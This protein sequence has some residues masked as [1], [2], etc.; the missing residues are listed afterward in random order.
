MRNRPAVMLG[1]MSAGWFFFQVTPT[2][3][4][5]VFVFVMD[6][7]ATLRHPASLFPKLNDVL[8]RIPATILLAGKP[9]WHNH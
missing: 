3:I 1:R 4:A 9:F 7:M 6:D 8:V 2:V 5:F